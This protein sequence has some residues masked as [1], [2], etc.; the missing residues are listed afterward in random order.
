[1]ETRHLTIMFTDVKGFTERTS[2]SS[3][4]EVEK[5]LELHDELL[6]PVIQ[7]HHGKIV[8]NI[9]D[10]FMVTFRSPTDAVLCGMKIQEKLKDYNSNIAEE[11]QIEIRVAINSGEVNI[12]KSDVFGEPV[13]VAARIAG[14]AEPNEVYFTESVFL[15]MNKKE[16]PSVE[17]GHRLLKGIPH[18]IKV[19][20]VLK[21]GENI[22][23]IK[24]IISRLPGFGTLSSKHW[25][26]AAISQ[27]VLILALQIIGFI[28]G[29]VIAISTLAYEFYLRSKGL[30][31]EDQ[32][33]TYG[34]MLTSIIPLILIAILPERRKMIGV[35]IQAALI[36]L[37]GVYE[38]VRRGR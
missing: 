22:K 10:A 4:E 32:F 26:I 33:S 34:W 31:I 2:H 9:G 5:L 36:F 24:K 21:E 28:I 6:V 23:K 30:K 35:F 19:Y 3:R 18:E 13:N 20:K 14:I 1:M 15:A 11:D 37:M 8:K 25:I 16:I 7:K 29:A 38:L 12:R 27:F 17:I